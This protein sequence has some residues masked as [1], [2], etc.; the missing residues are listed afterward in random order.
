MRNTI[1]AEGRWWEGVRI[2]WKD[3]KLYT[4][5]VAF[6]VA[7]SEC[8]LGATALHN[9]SNAQAFSPW[10]KIVRAKM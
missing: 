10:I 5:S 1:R 7:A 8:I 6:A 4:R 9:I 3:A 2:S